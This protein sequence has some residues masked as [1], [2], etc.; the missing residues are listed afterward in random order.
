MF[1]MQSNL[2]TFEAIWREKLIYLFIYLEKLIDMYLQET[3]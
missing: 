2:W 3:Y 1:S